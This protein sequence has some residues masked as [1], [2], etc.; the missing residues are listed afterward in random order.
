MAS[1]PRRNDLHVLLLLLWFGCSFCFTIYI[2]WWWVDM[3]CADVCFAGW[4][5][6]FA[7]F[8]LRLFLFQTFAF[9]LC[10]QTILHPPRRELRPPEERLLLQQLLSLQPVGIQLPMPSGRTL[11]EVGLIISTLNDQRSSVIAQKKK[12]KKNKQKDLFFLAAAPMDKRQEII[13]K[14]RTINSIYNLNR[15]SAYHYTTCSQLN[16][17][18]R[19]AP[20]RLQYNIYYL[21]QPKTPPPNYRSL[22][23]RLQSLFT[24]ILIAV[25]F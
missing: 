6:F 8:F 19:T 23:H 14:R 25:L 5:L 1:P 7:F 4:P 9:D 16:Q 3:S 13:T 22:F 12:E 20:N 24:C 11:P 17:N 2:S 10:F 15:L 21:H 18:K